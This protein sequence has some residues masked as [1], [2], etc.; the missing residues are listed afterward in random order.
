MIRKTS[1]FDRNFYIKNFLEMYSECPNFM[2][3]M[4]KQMTFKKKIYKKS[5]NF[6]VFDQNDTKTSHFDRSFY[7]KNV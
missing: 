6:L 5:P 3:N 1:H 2:K 4:Q 7:L